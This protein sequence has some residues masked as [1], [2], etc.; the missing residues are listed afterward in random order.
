M[1]GIDFT[2]PAFL[3]FMAL[4]VLCLIA[5]RSSAMLLNHR[6]QVRRQEQE[7]ELKRDLAAMGVPADEI[8]RIIKAKR[9]RCQA[10]RGGRDGSHRDGRREV[11]ADRGL[12]FVQILC[13]HGMRQAGRCR[14]A[15]CVRLAT[16]PMMN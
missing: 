11:G 14:A 2:L 8:E 3:A 16:M 10:S 12:S 15:C 1:M 9:R 13:E 7:T 4:L 6:Q 5:L